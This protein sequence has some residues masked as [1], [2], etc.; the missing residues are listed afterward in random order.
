[1]GMNWTTIGIIALGAGLG[2]SGL[3]LVAWGVLG[4]GSALRR[5]AACGWCGYA[6]LG[7]EDARCPE[8]GRSMRESE[9]DVARRG[10]VRRMVSG[11]VLMLLGAGCWPV[12]DAA[13]FGVAH[14]LPSVV[15][16]EW[17]R[18][19]PGAHAMVTSELQMRADSDRLRAWERRELARVCAGMVRREADG[20]MRRDAAWLLSR[21]G[22][23]TPA[24]ALV[25]MLKDRDDAV[26]TSGIEAVRRSAPEALRAW[27]TLGT[28]ATG[29][30]SAMV[31]KRA[32][33]AMRFMADEGHDTGRHRSTLLLAIED[34]SDTV[35]HSA[36]CALAESF[37]RDGAALAA[38]C[39]RA[40]DS[41]EDV[42]WAAAM[43]LGRMHD[44]HPRALNALAGSLRDAS[45]L[46]RASAAES[47]GHLATLAARGDQGWVVPRLLE[48]AL[49]DNDDMVRQ[50]AMKALRGVLG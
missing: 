43:A 37:E 20:A 31:R 47:L 10:T 48:S 41:S 9:L 46:V 22:P 44:A 42:R 18:C 4:P 30:R 36:V 34:P 29:D 35:R 17:L 1:M 23:E 21:L 25:V 7:L 32:I 24:D 49:V 19:S 26:R 27:G 13:Q 38:V 15:L 6:L 14:A 33:D 50:V 12:A 11:C 39:R 45:P 16:I 28:L 3:W 2:L 40:S 8:C 5:R